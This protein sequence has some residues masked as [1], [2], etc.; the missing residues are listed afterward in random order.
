MTTSDECG[1]VLTGLDGSNPLGFLA[2]VGVLRVLSDSNNDARM[3]WDATQDGWRPLLAGC[4][5]REE[6]LCLALQASLRE[7]STSIFDIGKVN[8]GNRTSSKFPFAADRFVDIL[9]AAVLRARAENR[10]EVDLFA[11]FGTELHPDKN[12]AFQSTSFKMVRSGDTNGQGMLFY[13]KALRE[14]LD[15][16]MLERSLFCAWDYGDPR[17]YRLRWDPI[18]DQRYA[19]R[20]DDPSPQRA[21][22]PGTM[23][24]ANCLAVE[25]LGCFPVMPIATQAQTTGFLGMHAR[26]KFVWPIWTVPLALETTRSL[27]SLPDIYRT[28][29]NRSALA[30]RGIDEV[31]GVQ[32]VR[33]NKYYSNFAPASPVL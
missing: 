29:L 3:A 7:A 21:S 16:R 20:W 17:D 13:A 27:L 30:K 28:P 8:E 12:G 11:A 1:L 31:Y 9:Q 4:G 26:T 32:L 19:L 5:D 22:G 24:A 2:A 14:S 18:E 33:P 25:A 10:R 6:H 15:Q 23:V